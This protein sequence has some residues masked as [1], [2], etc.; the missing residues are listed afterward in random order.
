MRRVAVTG[1]GVVAPSGVGVDELMDNLAA[2]RSGIG[3]LVDPALHGLRSPIGACAAFDAAG[4][5]R[6]SPGRTRRRR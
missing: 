6:P 1:L 3:R 5:A 4:V 2:G